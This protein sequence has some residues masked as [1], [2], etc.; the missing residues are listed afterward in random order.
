[1][2][3]CYCNNRIIEEDEIIDSFI[4]HVDEESLSQPSLSMSSLPSELELPQP[5][6]ECSMSTEIYVGKDFKD[7][8]Y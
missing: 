3:S 4:S 2:F 1:M 5:T 7:I 6:F 8:R